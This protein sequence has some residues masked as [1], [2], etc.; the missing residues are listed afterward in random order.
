MQFVSKRITVFFCRDSMKRVTAKGGD[1]I[2]EV[3]EVREFL[4]T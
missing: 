1:T 3:N 2:V 4:P